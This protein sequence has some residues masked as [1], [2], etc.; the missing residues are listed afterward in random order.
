MA[1]Y[2]QRECT[3]GR[4]IKQGQIDIPDHETRHERHKRWIYIYI[5]F[6]QAGL[7]SP[8]APRSWHF[9]LSC[10]NWRTSWRTSNWRR[11]TEINGGSFCFPLEHLVT[12]RAWKRNWTRRSTVAMIQLFA[13]VVPGFIFKMQGTLKPPLQPREFLTLW[14]D[15]ISYSNDCWIVSTLTDSSFIRK[16]R[17]CDEKRVRAL[18]ILRKINA[19]NVVYLNFY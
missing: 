13:R 17:K 4:C 15:T 12:I 1:I 16:M 10:I 19:S 2:I 11:V 18:P 9:G 6:F 14:F 5:F 8:T 7:T 3:Y